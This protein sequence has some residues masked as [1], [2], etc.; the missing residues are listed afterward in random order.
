MTTSKRVIL[1]LIGLVIAALLIF[2]AYTWVMLHVSY[3]DGERAGYLQKFS[4][5]GW[6]CKTW[7]GEILLTSMP[8][9]IP[10][11]FEFSVREEA[12]AQQL[13]AATGK[14]VVLSYA[15]HKGVPSQCFGETEYYI[16]KVQIQP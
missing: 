9:A 10:E 5:R 14:R 3:S 7:E 4:S 6:V 1:Y 8:G 15:Q 16:T 13:M 2:A 11:K 12:V